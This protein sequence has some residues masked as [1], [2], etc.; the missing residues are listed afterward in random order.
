MPPF[1]WLD[2]NVF[3]QIYSH[4]D[5]LNAAGNDRKIRQ[6][7]R[8]IRESLWAAMALCTLPAPRA[9]SSSARR[10]IGSSR[11]RRRSPAKGAWTAIPLYILREFGVFDGW[12]VQ[13]RRGDARV[14]GNAVDWLMVKIARRIGCP[15]VTRDE[16]TRTKKATRVG[17][18]ALQRRI[19][20]RGPSSRS[21]TR[22]PCS[23]VGSTPLSTA[24]STTTPRRTRER[25]ESRDRGRGASDPTARSG[26]PTWR[27]SHRGTRSGVGSASAAEANTRPHPTA[28]D[29]A[30]RRSTTAS[31][32]ARSRK[33]A[34]IT[35]PFESS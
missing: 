13:S 21:T 10:P 30:T 31:S 14:R 8:E 17:A 3:L 11:S 35:S 2:V 4:V 9:S 5:G 1:I 26:C 12:D 7:A 16:H 27:R 34:R 6:R 33:I 28:L 23:L 22:A 18:L 24:T 15:L 32:S 20:S 19:N 29:S 25:R